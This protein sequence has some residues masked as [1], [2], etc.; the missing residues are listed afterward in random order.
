MMRTSLDR[1]GYGSIPRPI[2]L[3]WSTV[4][5]QGPQMRRYVSQNNRTLLNLRGGSHF[6]RESSLPTPI[7][8]V[9]CVDWA[10]VGLPGGRNLL[11]LGQPL[12][13]QMHHLISELRLNLM[14]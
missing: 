4:R 8:L 2:S 6:K 3:L 14:G 10:S 5:S 11:G 9:C 7:G 13:G 1:V 12:L